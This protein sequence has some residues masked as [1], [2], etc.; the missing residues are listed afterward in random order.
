MRDHGLDE[1]SDSSRKR[2]IETLRRHCGPLVMDALLDPLTTDL[3]LNPDGKLWQKRAGCPREA[4]GTIESWRAVNI[5]KTL[6]GILDKEVTAQDPIMDGELP[7]GGERFAGQLPPI[8]AAPAFSIR[9][10]ALTIFPLSSYVANGI[11]TQRQCDALKAAVHQ[12]KNIL[13]SGGTGAGKTTL[14]N[15]IIE[16][17]DPGERLAILQDTAELQCAAPDAVM[18]FTSQY[19]D[20][21]KLLKACLRMVPDRIL[22][23][24][25]RGSEALDLVDAW[26][27]GHEGGVA[28]LHSNN[29][30]SALPRL[31]S[32]VSRNSQAPRER[33]DIEQLVAEVV[34]YVVH[35]GKTP[36][37]RKV[38]EL[39]EVV[40]YDNGRFQTRTI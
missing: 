31:V 24:E 19:V 28:T 29:A 27:T 5:V 13:V 20:L 10:P 38:Q 22:V 3:N 30:R 7:F 34:H 26:N 25:V 12:K 15:S 14:T 40:G 37:G 17:I 21:T 4:I 6:A 35:I 9:K 2:L 39:I 33:R 16:V 1:Q 32:M 8:V 36:E 18:L 11:M 23:G